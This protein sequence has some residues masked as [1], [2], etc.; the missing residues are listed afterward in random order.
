MGHNSAKEALLNEVGLY[1]L[2]LS[3]CCG[4]SEHV[5]VRSHHILQCP[6]IWPPKSASQDSEGL[7]HLLLTVRLSVP[8]LRSPNLV[9]F[10]TSQVCM[11][12]EVLPSTANDC[13]HAF[14]R[15]YA[16]GNQ[17]FRISNP[18]QL[19]SLV[20]NLRQANANSRDRWSNV[21]RG[22]YDLASCQMYSVRGL[23]WRLRYGFMVRNAV[24]VW[25]VILLRL[26]TEV[27]RR[28]SSRWIVFVVGWQLRSAGKCLLI[29]ARRKKAGL[30]EFPRNA[31]MKNGWRCD[32]AVCKQSRNMSWSIIVT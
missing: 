6:R 18:V 3:C 31:M 22:L 17:V 2:Y 21:C 26:R 9:A 16:R 20:N 24:R 15:F 29:T 4:W 12:V 10:T 13:S 11:W 1:V 5:K 19:L 30:F 23:P 7:V 28:L 27:N 8:L 32:N 14:I 25:H